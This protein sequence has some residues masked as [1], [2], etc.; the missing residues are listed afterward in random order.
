MTVSVR[1]SLCAHRR[2]Y[3][4]QID[5]G[6][7]CPCLPTDPKTYNLYKLIPYDKDADTRGSC[8]L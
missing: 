3:Y 7:I 4:T 2:L 6:D 8:L 1:D 5:Q